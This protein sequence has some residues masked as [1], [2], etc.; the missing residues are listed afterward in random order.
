MI[1]V[2]IE[3]GNDINSLTMNLTKQNHDHMPSV[4]A[5]HIR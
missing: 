3:L 2:D 4:R 5:Q 1:C